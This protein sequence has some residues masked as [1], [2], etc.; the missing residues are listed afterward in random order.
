MGILKM[1]NLGALFLEAIGAK[2]RQKEATQAPNDD[3]LWL[4]DAT[5]HEFVICVCVDTG[6]VAAPIGILPNIAGID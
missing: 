5:W 4:W 3:L 1:F 2:G 6:P